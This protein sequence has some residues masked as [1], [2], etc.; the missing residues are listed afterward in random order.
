MDDDKDENHDSELINC[1]VV[2]EE[3]RVSSSDNYS[4]QKV[5]PNYNQMTSKRKSYSKPYRNKSPKK[6]CVVLPPL[7]KYV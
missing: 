2:V 3:G 7:H 4:E 5:N 1:G 6:N